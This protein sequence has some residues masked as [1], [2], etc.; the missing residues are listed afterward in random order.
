MATPSKRV[1]ERRKNQAK[2]THNHK[3]AKL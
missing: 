1:S 2:R 3:L